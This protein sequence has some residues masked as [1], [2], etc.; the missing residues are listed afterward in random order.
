[1]MKKVDEAIEAAAEG[2][3][4]K[5][6]KKLSETA[7]KLDDK[8]EDDSLPEAQLVLAQ[9]ADLLGVDFDPTAERDDDD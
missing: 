7:K 6:E 9:L 4:D 8:L 1:M 3:E 2:D 5:A